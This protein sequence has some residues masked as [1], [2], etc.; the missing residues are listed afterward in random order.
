MIYETITSGFTIFLVTVRAKGT[1]LSQPY[2]LGHECFSVAAQSSQQQSGEKILWWKYAPS[3]HMASK[4]SW[5]LATRLRLVSSAFLLVLL[6]PS[7]HTASLILQTEAHA[8]WLLLLERQIYN[9]LSLSVTLKTHLQ[10][11]WELSQNVQCSV[12]LHSPH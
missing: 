10:F 12:H 5:D 7:M 8:W 1:F 2:C 6:D 11:P 3:A 4:F 9:C